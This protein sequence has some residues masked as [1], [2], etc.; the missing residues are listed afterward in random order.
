MNVNVDPST[1]AASTN[2]ALP[3][4]C[5]LCSS[6]SKSASLATKPKNGGNPAML[7]A[8]AAAMTSSAG[9]LAPSQASSR[10]SRVPVAW[11]ITPTTMNSVALNIA[12]AHNRAS[13]AS[14]MSPPPV[15]TITVIIPS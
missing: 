14:I 2:G 7:A 15:P 9:L 4:S 12:W 3:P 8:A 11:S 5:G 1:I 6:V 13:P 10:M